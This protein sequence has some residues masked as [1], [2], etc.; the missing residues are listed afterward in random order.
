MCGI[1]GIYHYGQTQPVSQPLLTRMNDCMIHRGPDDSG[2]WVDETI[3]LAMRRLAIIDLSGGHQPM[4]NED[5]T[6][7]IIFNGEIYNFQSLREELLKKGHPFKTSSD[8]EVILHLYEEEGVN[9]LK[10]LRGMFAFSLWDAK[11]KRLFIA[12]DRLGKKPLVYSMGA[13]RF[14]WASEIRA[15]TSLPWISKDIDREALDLYLGLQYI[16]SPWSIYQSVRK[17]PAAH[18]L[19]LENGRLTITRYWEPPLEGLEI[20]PSLEEAQAMIREKLTEATRLRMISEVPLGAFLSGGID[21][22]VVVALMS[23]LSSRPVKTFSIGFKDKKDS[24][25]PFAREVADFYNT[26][27]TEFVVEPHMVDVLPVLAAQYGEP[28]GD[29][30]ALPTYYLARETRKHVTVA[31]NGDGGDENFGGY[32][33][34]VPM[35]WDATLDVIPRPIRQAAGR[36]AQVLPMGKIHRVFSS[37]GQSTAGRYQNLIGIFTDEQKSRLYVDSFKKE[38]PAALSTR[39]LESFW[40]RASGLDSVNRLLFLDMNT[41]LPECLMPKV[42][43]ANMAH[44]LEGRSPLLDHEFIEAVFK[45]KG[46]WKLKGFKQLKWIFKNTFQDLLPPAIQK[47]EKRGFGLPVQSW[48][49]NE[50]NGVIREALFSTNSFA[51]KNFDGGYLKHLLNEHENGKRNHGYRLWNLLMLEFWSKSSAQ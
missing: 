42:D 15:L 23:R 7:W 1:A 14:S 49:Q 2:M 9:C 30:S 16:P 19:L 36:A 13:G 12:R 46:S 8:T 51:E 25:L 33:R 4:S 26:E 45:L 43:I 18:Y 28:F 17:L 38:L 27:H 41:Y 29:S 37:L 6:L 47:R 10:K 24:E 11:R 22:S 39:Y 3:G 32:M 20:S 5:G 31:L 44:S 40:N 21:S 50:L 34:Y 48:F 35:K